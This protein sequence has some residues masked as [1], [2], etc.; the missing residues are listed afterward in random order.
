VRPLLF[1]FAVTAMAAQSLAGHG[2]EAQSRHDEQALKQRYDA[3]V[4]PLD[5]RKLAEDYPGAVRNLDS[6]DPKKQIVGI[7]T[8]AA[9]EE[10]AAIP[11]IV[12][13]LD[14][15]DRGVRIYAGQGRDKS[16]PEK[17][18]ILPPGSGDIDLK[19]V[20]WVI[21]KMLQKP[22]DGNTHAFA[23]NMIGC[24]GLE[25]YQP[26]LRELLKSRHPAVTTAARRAL[27]M[28]GCEQPDASV[29]LESADRFKEVIQRLVQAINGQ[30]HA[31]IRQ[32]FNQAMLDDLTPDK[33]VLLQSGE[34]TW[35]DRETRRA[36]IDGSESGCCCRPLRSKEHGHHG[37]TG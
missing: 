12:P 16:H 22:D 10:V 25:E 33:T 31:A 24:L 30:D 1:L 26:E 15:E 6:P 13:F 9:T 36:T 2:G 18:V 23:A 21:L 20:S 14:S 27:E 34:S 19:P 37:R 3:F 11:L 32:D 4:E 8:L 35:Q 17:V 28:L 7:K 5:H 29:P